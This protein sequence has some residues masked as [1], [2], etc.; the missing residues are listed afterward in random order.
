MENNEIMKSSESA[1]E[2]IRKKRRKRIALLYAVIAVL[3]IA[4]AGM[5]ALTFLSVKRLS[6]LQ[7]QV[8]ELEALVQN[9]SD[10]S[11]DL[12]QKAQELETLE[13]EVA[14]PLPGG[15]SA[16]Q[17]GTISPSQGSSFTE[18]DDGINN[19]MT[20]VEDL[21]PKGNG[22]WSV[23]VCNLQSSAERSISNQPM[24][25]ASLIKLYIMGA[26]Y[27]NYETLA[28]QYGT[29]TLDSYLN[30]MITISDNDAANTLVTYLGGG[31][32]AAGMAAVNA[33][34]QAHG[35][36]GT[37]MGRLLLQD[38]TNGDN[39][40]TVEDCG[41][42]LKE[43]YRICNNTE[44]NPTLSHA[45]AMYALLKLQQRRN[46]IPAQMPEGVQVANKTG[47]LDTVENDAGII[48]DTAK[49]MDLVVCFM[50]ENLT[51]TGAAQ[52]CIADLSRAIY[53]FYN[54]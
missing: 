37:S 6:G 35:Y 2:I 1:K 9:I 20:Q 12:R 51:D 24:Q 32:S 15:T 42:F 3:L 7:K 45:D 18:E 49:N 27:E 30:S 5:T 52:S 54:E 8:A 34:C 50:S 13:Q 47:E 38:N 28:Q 31:D 40:T 41:R 25:A 26:V 23:Y 44:T 39:Y 14:G 46:K 10:T 11:A 33:F 29:D 4:L 36:T 53:G 48:Y 21:L 16:S 43:V 17:E 22:S 19:L